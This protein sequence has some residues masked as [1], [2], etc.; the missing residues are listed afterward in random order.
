MAGKI[1]NLRL[2]LDE[3]NRVK[4]RFFSDSAK[5]HV[6]EGMVFGCSGG[7]D[8][9]IDAPEPFRAGW[10]VGHAMFLEAAAF[11][12]TQAEKGRKSAASRA[13]K[14][15]TA[16]PTRFEHGSTDS[17]TRFDYS[18]NLTTIDNRQSTNHERQTNPP[19]V[20]PNE[21]TSPVRTALP[22]W[23]RTKAIGFADD[24]RTAT[25][26]L[27]RAKREPNRPS[28]IADAQKKVDTAKTEIR[29]LGIEPEFALSLAESAVN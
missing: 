9:P 10:E 8:L 7:E 15:G 17:R 26:A 11:H 20:P 12:E 6:F 18:P 22:D 1:W 4:G 14:H 16:Q 3:L 27:D 21:K 24:L 13:Q 2:N 29:K 5:L 25:K 19:G 23:K 28:F